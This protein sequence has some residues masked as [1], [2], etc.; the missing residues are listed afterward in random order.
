MFF[1]HLSTDFRYL[2]TTELTEQQK[3]VVKMFKHAWKGYKESAW[4]HDHAHPISKT[5]D[6]WFGIGLTLI[7]ALDTMFI[8]GLE[9][10]RKLIDDRNLWLTVLSDFTAILFSWWLHLVFLSVW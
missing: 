8:M 9:K 1:C 5:H 6:D 7:D 3:F 10:G 2:S 4:G